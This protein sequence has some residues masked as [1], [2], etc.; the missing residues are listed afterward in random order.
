MTSAFTSATAGTARGLD[1]EQLAI[2][3]RPR[4]ERLAARLIWDAEE[5]RDLM[6]GALAQAWEQR[7]RLH[8]PSAGP[9]WLRRIVVHRAMSLLRRRRLWRALGTL[10]LVAPEAIDAQSERSDHLTRL[11][12]CLDALPPRQSTAFSLRYLEGLSI[13]ETASSMAI[14]RGTVRV[15]LQRAIK[16]LRAA[17][18]LPDREST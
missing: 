8:D 18:A 10:L 9:A 6:Q 13:D 14:D 7:E 12:S 17:G 4:L 3:E 2:A 15:H 5:A 1:L 16:A 11:A